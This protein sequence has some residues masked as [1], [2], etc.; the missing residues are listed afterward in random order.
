[1]FAS[2]SFDLVLRLVSL[3]PE[4]NS[5]VVQTNRDGFGEGADRK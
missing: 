5:G 2:L 4:C 1:M 3:A